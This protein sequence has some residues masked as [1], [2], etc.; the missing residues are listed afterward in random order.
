MRKI[1]HQRASVG[2]NGCGSDNRRAASALRHARRCIGQHQQGARPDALRGCPYPRSHRAK[3]FLRA[4]V[5]SEDTRGSSMK[6]KQP[7]CVQCGERPVIL[8]WL[9]GK[10]RRRTDRR[11]DLCRKCFKAAQEKA[12]HWTA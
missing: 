10:A 6:R 4:R 1:A 7:R 12:Q 9:G 3:I 8:T 5:T 2:P 11:H